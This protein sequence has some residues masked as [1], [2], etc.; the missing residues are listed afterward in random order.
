MMRADAGLH[1]NQAGRHVGK[2]CFTLAT[3]PLLMQHD[4]AALRLAYDM[5]RVLADIDA[6]HGDCGIEFLRHGVLLV[7]G[8]PDQHR[9]LA[10][11]EHGPTIPLADV[12]I[13]PRAG[14]PRRR[15]IARSSSVLA[16]KRAT[17][18][19]KRTES[20]VGRNSACDFENIPFAFGFRRRL[21][22]QQIHWVYFS[23]VF[24]NGSL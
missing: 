21:D 24:A 14:A 13:R 5:E 22:L 6:D 17:T 8:A 9:L 23:T 19:R 20:L 3:R 4:R 11:Q 18:F 12:D 15:L 2:A 1:A 10:G 7:F 16:N